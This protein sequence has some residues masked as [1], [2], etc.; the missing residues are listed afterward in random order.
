MCPGTLQCCKLVPKVG[1]IDSNFLIVILIV[2]FLEFL[3]RERE[4]EGGREEQ[5]TREKE[6][7][8]ERER[9][10]ERTSS[11]L[12]TQLGAQNGARSHDPGIMTQAK[13]KSRR[14]N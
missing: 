11:R 8:R 1:V 7:E 13:I 9:E 2:N 4:R 10:R 5:R 14:L 6:K 12:H 3:E